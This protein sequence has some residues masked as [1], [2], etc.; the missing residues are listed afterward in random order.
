VERFPTAFATPA[1]FHLGPD[2]QSRSVPRGYGAEAEDALLDSIG[3]PTEG[4]R[5]FDIAAIAGANPRGIVGPINESCFLTLRRRDWDRVAGLDEAFTSPGGGA[6]NLDL[7]DRLIALGAMPVVLLR[8]GSFHQ[9]HVGVTTGSSGPGT[10]DIWT[11]YE[12][13][14]GR[15]YRRP[16]FDPIYLGEPSDPGERWLRLPSS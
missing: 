12:R 2:H 6:M 14:R 10:D 1:A 4:Y 8:E 9:V 11:E 3:W 7:F 16:E 5:L 13:I 15:A